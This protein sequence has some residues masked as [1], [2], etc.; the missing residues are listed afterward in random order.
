MIAYGHW[1]INNFPFILAGIFGIGGVIAFHELGHFLFCKLFNIYVST[2]SIGFGP[3]ILKKKIGETL[4][5]IS[6][7]PIGGYVEIEMGQTEGISSERYIDT[8]PY[9]QKFLVVFGGILFNLIFGFVVLTGLSLSGIPSN[10]FLM[11]SGSYAIKKLLPQSPAENAGLQPGDKILTINTINVSK[12]VEHLMQT[13]EPLSGQQASIT[14]E[15]NGTTQTIDLV[16]GSQE[17]KG[18]KRGVIGIEEFLFSCIS[19]TLFF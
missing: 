4:F 18:K 7:I 17:T 19:S 6:L 11:N 2:F 1:I 14:F 16:V 3:Q 12:K 9:W 15:R 13:L 10:P 8:K 5:T